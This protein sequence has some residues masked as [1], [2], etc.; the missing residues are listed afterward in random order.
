MWLHDERPFRGVEK[1]SAA[2]E[3][4]FAAE[5]F[6]ARDVTPE[7]LPENERTTIEYYLDCLS[8]QFW[9][10]KARSNISRKD[11]GG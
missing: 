11:T 6:M 8:K 7:L 2:A 9:D 5:R 3:F 10:S 4:I 1:I